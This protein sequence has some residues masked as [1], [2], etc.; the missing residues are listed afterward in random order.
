MNLRNTLAA[1]FIVHGAFSLAQAYPNQSDYF[2]GSESQVQCKSGDKNDLTVTLTR[3][4]GSLDKFTAKVEQTA[5][6]NF[7]ETY[8]VESIT[9]A[10][11][12][13]T[14]RT[15]YIS[16]DSED[17]KFSQSWDYVSGRMAG[18]ALHISINPKL[19]FDTETI[20]KVLHP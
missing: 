6:S 12:A 14:S 3:L 16:I 18:V 20:C 10:T 7:S 13:E 17:F 4:P 1:L 9:Q 19:K 5:P 11:G 15:V 2:N 8:S